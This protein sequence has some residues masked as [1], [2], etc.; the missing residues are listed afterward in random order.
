MDP[1]Q[2]SFCARSQAPFQ[3]TIEVIVKVEGH[4][5][6]TDQANVRETT[7]LRCSGTLADIR[8]PAD[9]RYPRERYSKHRPQLSWAAL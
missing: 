1:K 2:E 8:H 9:V 6:S 4:R 5:S 7:F 3:I